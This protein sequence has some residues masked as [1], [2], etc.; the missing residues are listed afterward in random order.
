MSWAK[1]DDQ[2]ADHPKVRALGV[3]GIAIQAAAICHCARYLTDGFLSASSADQILGSVLAPFTLAD[4]RLVTPLLTTEKQTSDAVAWDWKALMID[5]GLWEK[6]AK[7]YRVHDYLDY[8][9]TRAKV[10]EDRSK[11][12]GRVR[13]FRGQ[14]NGVTNGV[15][16]G[17]VRPSRP[18]PPKNPPLSPL[19]IDTLADE[20]RGREAYQG[21]DVRGAI[22]RC[23]QYWLARGKPL[24]KRSAV[25]WL[26]KD[27]ADR[28][29]TNGHAS[30]PAGPHYLD[31][32]SDE[33]KRKDADFADSAQS[34]PRS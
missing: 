27:A 22:L 28:V 6:S 14:G 23:E 34:R 16:T 8:N 30:K 32:R 7:G 4:G 19:T 1:L 5:A 25:N 10:L 31:L 29:T 2:F 20:L 24:T 12:A 21:L 26:N 3:Y 17:V 18:R 11:T 15:S 33:H 13:R 9:P